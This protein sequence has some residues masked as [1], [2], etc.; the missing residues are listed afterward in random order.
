MRFNTSEEAIEAAMRLKRESRSVTNR[1]QHAIWWDEKVEVLN[2]INDSLE[3]GGL[4]EEARSDLHA[5]KTIIYNAE[6]Y[7]GRYSLT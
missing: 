2:A 6:A 4:S 3:T 7:A 5:A 1:D